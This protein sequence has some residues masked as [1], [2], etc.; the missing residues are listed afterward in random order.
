MTGFARV[1]GHDGAV[2]WTWELKS[3]NGRG[4]DLRCR[5]AP[6]W[7]A[8]EP[9]AREAIGKRFKRGSLN[10]ALAVT[11]SAES[12]AVRVNEAVLAMLVDRANALVRDNPHL[13]PAR[14][15]GLLALRGVIETSDALEDEATRQSR[16]R[17]VLASFAQAVDALA[18]MRD[19]E[20]RRLAEVL[21]AQLDRISELAARAEQSATMRPE[22]IG[23]RLRAQVAA[24]IDAAPS[25]SDE[26]LMQEAALLAAKGDVREELDRLIAH[27]TAAREMLDEGG[28][29]GRRLDFLCQEFN[30]EA[31]TLCSKAAEVE[32][33]R[34]GLEL[35]AVIEQFREQVQNI[36]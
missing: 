17:V 26:R 23:E 8:L 22:A 3:V 25:L 30:R 10:V 19:A 18:A 1:Q 7:D 24:L 20:G 13:A 11:H 6:G 33:T 31:N 36:E 21:G 28:A 12:G 4:L 32:L 15:D 5:L 2:A 34:I 9:A 14:V 16:E 27:V 35:K 29:I